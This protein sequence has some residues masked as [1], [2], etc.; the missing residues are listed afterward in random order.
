MKVDIIRTE[1]GDIPV[2]YSKFNNSFHLESIPNELKGE[3][4]ISRLLNRE[5]GF[6]TFQELKEEL[7]HQIFIHRLNFEFERKVIFIDFSKSDNNYNGVSMHLK[8]FIGDLGVK[9]YKDRK[10]NDLRQ[11]ILYISEH[12]ATT[13]GIDSGTKKI[14]KEEFNNNIYD[15]SDELYSNLKQKLSELNQLSDSIKTVL[16]LKVPEKKNDDDLIL[17][18]LKF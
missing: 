1:F 16:N 18:G 2:S 3:Q 7:N 11:A 14:S 13:Y 12:N 9:H 4:S 15:Y 10:G 8:Y 17:H 5:H 6:S